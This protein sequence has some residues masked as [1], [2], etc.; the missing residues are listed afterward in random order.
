MAASP[1]PTSIDCHIGA[2]GNELAG[3]GQARKKGDHSTAP[4]TPR[5]ELRA[6]SGSLSGAAPRATTGAR[7]A[8]APTLS[9]APSA[10]EPYWV[11]FCAA[12][13]PSPPR[14]ARRAPM[15][16]LASTVARS[17]R[18][19]GRNAPKTCAFV[20]PAT[21]AAVDPSD[22]AMASGSAGGEQ[23][24]HADVRAR[25]RERQW[26]RRPPGRPRP[27]RRAPARDGRSAP[28]R[29]SRRSPSSRAEAG[30]RRDARPGSGVHSPLEDRALLDDPED[31]VL[32]ERAR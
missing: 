25:A 10:C 28:S 1:R 29:R 21:S 32:D 22:A 14:S 12:S 13:W 16:G 20:K 18:T 9:T 15:R 17:S 8:V 7:I 2:C 31:Q 11:Q 23:E 19:E 6:R 3:E 27:G 26:R 5:A 24:E 4:P 30:A